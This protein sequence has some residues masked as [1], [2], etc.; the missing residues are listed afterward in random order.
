MHYRHSIDCAVEAFE[1]GAQTLEK[2]AQQFIHGPGGST[3]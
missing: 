2:L 1:E 3:C